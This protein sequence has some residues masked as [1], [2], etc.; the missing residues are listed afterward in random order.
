MNAGVLKARVRPA[1]IDKA[2]AL[3]RELVLGGYWKVRGARGGQL[4]INRQTGDMLS[5]GLYDDAGAARAFQPI[6]EQALTRL[7]PYVEGDRPSREIYELAASTALTTSSLA[8]AFVAAINARD[9]EAL[10]RLTASEVELSAPGRRALKGSQ[11]V[12]EY[13]LRLFRAFPDAVTRVERS[14]AADTSTVLEASF[15]GTH[16]GPLATVL[17]EISPTGRRVSSSYVVVIEADRGLIRSI[18]EYFDQLE[19][20]AQMGVAPAPTA[21]A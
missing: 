5:V 10:A 4:W 12:K 14:I 11:P 17:G 2:V 15:S 13:Y 1:A 20:L 18:R 21:P 16:A 19:L 6:A 9:G 3:Y 8:E 7:E